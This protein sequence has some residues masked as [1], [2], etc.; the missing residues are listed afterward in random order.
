MR[1][2]VINSA[3]GSKKKLISSLEDV[4]IIENEFESAFDIPLSGKTT[5]QTARTKGTVGEN[6]W[7]NSR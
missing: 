3:E 1:T 4:S 6:N 5:R 7:N 2:H